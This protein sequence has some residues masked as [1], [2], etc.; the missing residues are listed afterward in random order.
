MSGKVKVSIEGAY[1]HKAAEEVATKSGKA[2]A[3]FSLATSDDRK[4]DGRWERG[5]AKW[6]NCIAFGENAEKA[7]QVLTGGVRGVSVEGRLT[8]EEY[9]G[10]TYEKVIVEHIDVS[11]SPS[12]HEKAKANGYVKEPESGED[13]ADIPF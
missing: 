13:D 6:W 9:G 4:V 11:E 12:G 1:C 10:R 7:K 3:R 8:V 5:P 2:M